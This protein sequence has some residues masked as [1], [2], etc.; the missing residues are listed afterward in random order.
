MKKLTA[1]F[2]IGEDVKGRALVSKKP[3]SFLGGL[4]TET[5]TIIDEEHDLFGQTVK[6]K[7]LVYPFGKGSTGDCMRLWRAVH[8]GVGPVAIINTTPDP[9]HVEGA[10]LAQIPLLFGCEQDPTEIIQNGAYITI[11]AGVIHVRE[12]VRAKAYR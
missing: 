6:G 4:N 1:K 10:L 9:I 3:L 7:I 8:N 5:G 11:T 12:S 2:Y